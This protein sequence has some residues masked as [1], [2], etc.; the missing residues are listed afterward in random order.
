[1]VVG[2]RRQIEEQVALY[3]E[4]EVCDAKGTRAA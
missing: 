1:V 2:D 3:G 4:L